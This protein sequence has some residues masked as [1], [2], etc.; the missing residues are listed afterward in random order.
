MSSWAHS[1]LPPLTSLNPDASATPRTRVPATLP[2][3]LTSTVRPD[4][5]VD[6]GAQAIER[7]CAIRFRRDVAHGHCRRQVRRQVC[8]HAQEGVELRAT[9]RPVA[10]GKQQA[11]RELDE[12]AARVG[13]E[14]LPRAVGSRAPEPAQALAEPRMQSRRESADA[15]RLRG[16][17]G[18]DAL[19]LGIGRAG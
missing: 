1:N 12:L 5:D 16:L 4:L 18:H 9:G 19:D 6:V 10:V 7:L 14:Q 11:R 8:H 17:Q 13:S 3:S 2:F 15:D